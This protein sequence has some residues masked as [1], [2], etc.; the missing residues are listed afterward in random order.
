LNRE[1][2]QVLENIA[3]RY[4]TQKEFELENNEMVFQMD[5]LVGVDEQQQDIQRVVDFLK[6]VNNISEIESIS[7]GIEF[8][9]RKIKPI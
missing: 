1:E 6:E 4:K 2:I 5:F 8:K 7:T 9:L 3:K